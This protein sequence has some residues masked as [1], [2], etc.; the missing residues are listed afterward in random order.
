MSKKKLEQQTKDKIER[1]MGQV[2]V[3]RSEAEL[4][5]VRMQKNQVRMQKNK[6]EDDA[7]A[8]QALQAAEQARKRAA[9]ATPIG[10]ATAERARTT[11]NL[12]RLR[13][14]DSAASKLFSFTSYFARTNAQDH[15]NMRLISI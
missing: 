6:N 12:Q 14:L 15:L 2:R 8:L 13:S 11:A 9:A 7:R 5:Q 1:W 4:L 10:A 3:E